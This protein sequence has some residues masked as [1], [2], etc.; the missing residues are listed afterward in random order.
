MT[1]L[2][3]LIEAVGGITSLARA[4]EITHPAIT[5]WRTKNAVPVDR[6]PALVRLA[7]DHGVDLRAEDLRDDI[8]WAAV[9]EA[10]GDCAGPDG[11]VSHAG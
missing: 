7:L 10:R 3:Q 9:C 4:L 6:V 5:H 8:D 1:K 2:D 11:G